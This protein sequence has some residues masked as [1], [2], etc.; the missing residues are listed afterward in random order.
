MT[1]KNILIVTQA[2]Y[3]ENSPRSFRAT[4]LAKEFA[5]SGHNVTVITPRHDPVHAAFEAEFG[6]LIKD[7]GKYNWKS[8]AVKG[9][10]IELFIR[11]VVSRFSNL[12]FEYP[13][14]QLLGLVKKALKLEAGYD[15]MVSIAVPY[16]IHWGVA[17]ARTKNRRI[18]KVWVADCGDPYVGREN[19]TFNVPFYFKYVEKWF[20]RK[21][22]FITV[23]TIGSIPAY[24]REFHAKI[25]VI[26]QGFRFEDITLYHGAKESSYPVFAYGGAFIPG[27]RDP[28]ELLAYLCSL[29]IDF[30]FRVFTTT[31]DMVHPY[32]ALSN[33]RIKLMP[34]IPRKELLFEL[35]KFDFLVNFEN[36]GNRQTPSKLID[37]AIINKPI[38]S[39]KTGALNKIAVDEFL[40]GDYKNRV[41]IDHPEQYRIENVC[42]RFLSLL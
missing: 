37:Y 9:S 20:C 29:K 23:P 28:T 8:L 41:I 11:R 21:T 31:P 4:E 25:R 1:S 15:L 13:S 18:A 33:G 30:E 17:A 19:D 39:V 34:V 6:I 7:L 24:F 32:V 2:F 22:D 16:P 42:Q 5:R 10:G 3:P 14:I 26:S 38:L 12:L 27:M 35:S 40:S 36:E